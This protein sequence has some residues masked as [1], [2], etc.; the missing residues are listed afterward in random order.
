MLAR[1]AF[2]LDAN[3]PEAVEQRRRTSQRTARENV[4]A[5]VDPGSFIEF[6]S[7][8]VAAQAARRSRD[9]LMRNTSG[10]G[11]VAGLASVNGD[12]FDAT[13]ARCMVVAYDYTVLAGTQGARNH[14]KQDRLYAL[15][16]KQRLPVILF[17]EG[18]VGRPG[19]T[20]GFWRHRPR[21]AD[22]RAVRAAQRACAARRR[23]LGPVLRRQCGA[24]R[25]LRRDRRDEGREDRHGRPGHDRGRGLEV[26]RPEEVGPVS[27]QAPNGVIDVVV[28]DEVEAAGTARRYLSFFQGPIVA[29]TPPPFR[30]ADSS[31]IRAFSRR[32]RRASMAAVGMGAVYARPSSGAPL[33]VCRLPT[34]EWHPGSVKTASAI[35]KAEGRSGAGQCD[36]LALPYG[37]DEDVLRRLG[38]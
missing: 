17:A 16:E 33:C 9:D 18:G 26:V 29:W 19:D 7:L 11:V 8:A 10:D 24:A 12:L 13:H 35:R 1:Q 34:D 21:R 6:G 28:E 14:K 3:R 27:M 32:R 23:R 25:L 22:L 15:A 20:E 4:T 37:V 2:G 31:P 30:S 38:Q 36:R 5:L